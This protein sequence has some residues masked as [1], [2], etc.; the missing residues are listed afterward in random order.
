MKPTRALEDTTQSALGLLFPTAT[1]DEPPN[2][3]AETDPAHAFCLETPQELSKVP[4]DSP[5]SLTVSRSV[6]PS[7]TPGDNA[8][9]FQIYSLGSRSLSLLG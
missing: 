9:E 6:T 2:K 5:G 7:L 4:S 1:D 8:E 3:P